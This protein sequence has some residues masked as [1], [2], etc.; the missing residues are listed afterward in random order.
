MGVT[1]FP[2]SQEKSRYNSSEAEEE[3]SN[4]FDEHEAGGGGYVLRKRDTKK[5]KKNV[6]PLKKTTI[7]LLQQQR[8][9]TPEPPSD[10][11]S[12]QYLCQH[13]SVLMWDILGETNNGLE[14]LTYYDVRKKLE[15][16][17]NEVNLANAK[18]ESQ[19][20]SPSGSNVS[21]TFSID[22]IRAYIKGFMLSHQQ[23]LNRGSRTHHIHVQ[24]DGWMDRDHTIL[25]NEDET[26]ENCGQHVSVAERYVNSVKIF[27]VFLFNILL[28]VISI[29]GLL[30]LLR[31]V[32]SFYNYF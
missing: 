21:L 5:K 12:T 18:K 6:V 29:F 27:T 11:Y 14:K 3:M 13:L 20:A 22:R 30:I 17:L 8:G 28:L 32:Y 25:E 16:R 1:G 4:D 26:L 10:R 7:K 9:K 24:S 23:V 19:L 15:S 31:Y 2:T